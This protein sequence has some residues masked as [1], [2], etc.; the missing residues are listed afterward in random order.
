MLWS[1]PDVW[2]ALG[3][4]VGAVENTELGFVYAF[5][6]QLMVSSLGGEE[7]LLFI[8]LQLLALA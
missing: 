6:I 2:S 8:H 7:N 4:A 5:P 3:T 1:V